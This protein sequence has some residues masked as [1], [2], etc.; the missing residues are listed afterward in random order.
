MSKESIQVG[1]KWSEVK[2]PENWII[3]AGGILRLPLILGKPPARIFDLG[4]GLGRHTVYFA[5][6]GYDIEAC[7]ISLEA[8][9]K[10]REWLVKE[11][12]R[13]KITQNKMTDL[14]QP[15][16][17]YDLII[18]YNVIYHAFQEDII[19]TINE[20]YR[21]LKPGGLF[22]GTFLTKDR[23][24]PF[25]RGPAT[26][27]DEQ[28][29]I[30]QGGPEDG[31]PHFFSYIENVLEF[32]MDFEILSIEFVSSFKKPFSVER[33]TNQYKT[34]HYIFLAKKPIK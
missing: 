17:K 11:N 14:N 21:I 6:L 22:F 31:I 13:A 16:N 5:S 34:G 28:T 25:Q 20:I 30:I 1:W 10:T 26:I 32:L 3:P 27:I 18:G 24:D 15:N 23:N 7:D 29:L 9:E 33:I 2:D 4:C 19:K 8:V 12:L